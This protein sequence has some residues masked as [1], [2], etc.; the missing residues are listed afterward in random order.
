MQFIKQKINDLVLIQPVVHGDSRGFFMETYRKS[1]FFQNGIQ[2]DFIQSNHAKSS[3][4]V[5]RGLHYQL[6][7]REQGKLVRVT[8]GAVLDVAVDIRKSSPTFGKHVM[9]EL[10]EENK[11]IFWVPPGFAHGYIT[12][13]NDTEFQY[14]VTNEY[15]PEHERGICFDDPD[16]GI[17]WP[18]AVS[19]LLVSERDKSLPLLKDQKDLFQ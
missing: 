12:L 1:M 10:T 3:K 5:L 11:H 4:N 19:E 6:E 7:P 14:Q 9:V 13:T 17:E 16:I 2:N 18:V 15:S 8:R